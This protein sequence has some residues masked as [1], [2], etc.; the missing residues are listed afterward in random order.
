MQKAGRAPV[1]AFMASC[2]RPG[3][4]G[5]GCRYPGIGKR[6]MAEIRTE[7]RT[8]PAGR[9]NAGPST[10]TASDNRLSYGCINV[11]AALYDRHIKHVHEP[12]MRCACACGGD[13][14]GCSG[15]IPAKDERELRGHTPSL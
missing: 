1:V 9:F 6:P 12:G 2:H 5:A 11:P 7:D 8:T 13:A 3:E 4:T 10:N 15:S 14:A